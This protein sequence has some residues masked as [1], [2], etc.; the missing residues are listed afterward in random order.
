[1]SGSDHDAPAQTAKLGDKLLKLIPAP[2]GARNKVGVSGSG[3]V[4][5]AKIGG[6]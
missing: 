1:M 4:S 3:V 2:K 5:T 6:N